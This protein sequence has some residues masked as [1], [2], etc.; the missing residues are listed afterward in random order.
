M[1]LNIQ[2]AITGIHLI[3]KPIII[4]NIILNQYQNVFIC[5]QINAALAF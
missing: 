4:K 2:I 5:F 3:L 1:M